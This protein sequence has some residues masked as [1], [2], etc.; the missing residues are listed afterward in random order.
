MFVLFYTN[1][2]KSR[3]VDFSKSKNCLLLWA[4]VVTFI[5]LFVL[6]C[7]FGSVTSKRA[8]HYIRMYNLLHDYMEVRFAARRF[9]KR[10]SSILIHLKSNYVPSL[11]A[12]WNKIL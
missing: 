5:L 6:D 4:E 2:V 10:L 11:D 7:N 1:L 9:I 8:T 12:S 3:L